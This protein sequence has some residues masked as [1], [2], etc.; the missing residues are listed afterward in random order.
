M[1]NTALLGSSDR[2]AADL[3]NPYIE[4]IENAVDLRQ[5][6]YIYEDF[7]IHLMMLEDEAYEKG[8]YKKA[9]EVGVIGSVIGYMLDDFYNCFYP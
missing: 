6:R 4:Q 2:L 1:Y 5:L 9:W 7:R 8:E 3:L